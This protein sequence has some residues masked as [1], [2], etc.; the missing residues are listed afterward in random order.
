MIELSADER[1]LLRQ[2]ADEKAAYCR[3]C[4]ER[5]LAPNRPSAVRAGAAEWQRLA[6]LWASIAV[7]VR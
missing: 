6:D 3:R 4:A 2:T 1:A 7:K 5:C